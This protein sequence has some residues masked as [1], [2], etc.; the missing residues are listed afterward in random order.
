M[1][2]NGDPRPEDDAA[3]AQDAPKLMV[4]RVLAGGHDGTGALISVCVETGTQGPVTLVIDTLKVPNFIDV[5]AAALSRAQDASERAGNQRRRLMY[6]VQRFAV[7]SMDGVAGVLLT[8][9]QEGPTERHY[10]LADPQRALSIAQALIK[11]VGAAKPTVIHDRR[12]LIL[13]GGNGHR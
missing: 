6:P 5:I 4:E 13:P 7:G 8:L 1:S 3:A 12:R 2:D 11:Q 9:N 10:L